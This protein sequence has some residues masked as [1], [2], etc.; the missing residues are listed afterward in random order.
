MLLLLLV[1]KPRPHHNTLPACLTLVRQV[2]QPDVCIGQEC[3]RIPYYL[4]R[5]AVIPFEERNKALPWK[6][7]RAQ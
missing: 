7:A 6:D 2:R 3:I 5:K 4:P 1:A